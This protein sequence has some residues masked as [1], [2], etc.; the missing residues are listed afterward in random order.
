[1]TETRLFSR[2]CFFEGDIQP[3]TVYI[4]N[5]KILKIVEEEKAPAGAT[6]LGDAVLMP[7]CI[8]AHVHINE[9]GRT[10][11][12]GFDTAT[13]AAAAGG[14][15]SLV[16]MP[17]NSTPVTIDNASL[18]QKLAASEGKLH[19]HVGFY[20]GL[21]PGNANQMDA[22]AQGGVLGIKAFLTHSGIEDFPNATI[23]DLEAAMPMLAKLKLPLL[24]HCELD[25]PGTT[26]ALE[27]DPRSYRAYLASRPKEWENRAVQQ[28]IDLCRK[29]RCHVHIV[30]VSSAEA[31]PLIKAAKKEGLPLTA[32]TCPQYLLFNAE[33]IPD[34]QTQYK[35]APPIR[36]RENNELLKEALCEGVLDFIT[37]DHSPAPPG[38]KE[39]ESGNLLRAWGGIAGLQF[40]L[41]A[42]WTALRDTL[43]LEQF[44]PLITE[45]P[46]RFLR[47]EHHKGFLLPGYDADLVAWLP[48]APVRIGAAAV[49]HKHKI[50]PYIDHAL[51]GRVQQTW[52]AGEA[53]LAPA[54][55]AK[56]TGTW[57]LRK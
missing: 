13:R 43:S 25:E 2:R 5:G 7:G 26:E 52:V 42:S 16:D 47:L 6:D 56:P 20:G 32:E 14:S 33:D 37:T 17:L 41:P 15:T 19:V 10:E 39:L 29:Y 54:A 27:A 23:E 35:C 40:L 12:E 51:F 38:T 31:L 8:D 50:S 3:G 46:A 28:M 18:Q 45:A 36:E 11:W 34:G 57:L 4:R 48:E 30:H 22:L 24:V 53:Q 55:P 49:Q 21:V 44:I 1:M 9:P